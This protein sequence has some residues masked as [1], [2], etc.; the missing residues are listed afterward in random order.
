MNLD[1]LATSII[2][3]ASEM[4]DKDKKLVMQF[5]DGKRQLGPKIEDLYT[6]YKGKLTN[7]DPF[8]GFVEAFE[9]DDNVSWVKYKKLLKELAPK[10]KYKKGF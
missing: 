4:D 5:I 6:K 2:R 10:Q 7:K 9:K 1:K 3:A 8:F